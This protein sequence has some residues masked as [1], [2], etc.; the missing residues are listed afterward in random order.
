M[1]KVHLNS[2]KLKQ[3]AQGLH[4]SILGPLSRYCYNFAILMGLLSV[5]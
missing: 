2:Q 4:C 5:H 1:S 3:H